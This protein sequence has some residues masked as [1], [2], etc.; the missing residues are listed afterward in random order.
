MHT[1][2]QARERA[3]CRTLT[4]DIWTNPKENEGECRTAT[5]PCIASDCMAWRWA[6]NKEWRDNNPST[7]SDGWCGLAGTPQ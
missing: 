7:K 3:C 6:W 2:E 1:E 4:A 5:T